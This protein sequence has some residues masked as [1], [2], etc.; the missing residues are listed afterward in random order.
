MSLVTSTS[1]KSPRPR[2]ERSWQGIITV[3]WAL[4]ENQPVGPKSGDERVVPIGAPLAEV[5]TQAMRGKFRPPA[6]S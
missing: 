4:S 6:W 1:T 5:L 2:F 3:R